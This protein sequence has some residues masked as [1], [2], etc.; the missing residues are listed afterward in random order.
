MANIG[1]RCAKE[2]SEV[3]IPDQNRP[4]IPI[5][6]SAI[7][8]D[9]AITDDF[10]LEVEQ[11]KSDKGS[12]VVESLASEV[13]DIQTDIYALPT[14][15]FA[16]RSRFNRIDLKHYLPQAYGREDSKDVGEE[17]T[18]ALHGLLGWQW[19]WAEIGLFEG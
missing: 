15:S 1:R 8:V 11:V 12:P 4:L 17:T 7:A 3:C 13:D 5:L 9:P 14:R 18:M 19:P 10:G 2:V 6:A 16:E